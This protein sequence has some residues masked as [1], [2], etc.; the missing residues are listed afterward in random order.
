MTKHNILIINK[1]I[2]TIII[3]HNYEIDF[4]DN[5][6]KVIIKY[7]GNIVKEYERYKLEGKINKEIFPSYFCILFR[8]ENM[9][10]PILYYQYNSELEQISYS[11]NY[12]YNSKHLKD[13]P[14]PSVPEQDN[15][16]SY[17]SKYEENNIN[18]TPS[19]FIFL[20][21][22]SG[23]M[24]GRPI[25]L[26]KNALLLFIQ[27]LPKGSFFQLIGFGSSYN[28]YNEKPVEYNKENVEKISYTINNLKA[29]LGGTNINSPLQAVYNDDI[30]NNI[31]L[32]KNI[33]LLTDC[34][35]ND[36]EECI[37]IINNNSNRFRVHSLGL[38]D[39]FD[40]DLIEKS[41]QIGKGSY[42][43]V[44]NY[45]KINSAVIDT[46]NKSLRPYLIDIQFNFLNNINNNEKSII[47]CKPINN[48]T[49]QNEIINYS[50]ILDENNKID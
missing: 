39:S 5:Y 19:L 22:Q 37:N 21:D 32:S 45:E 18:D 44:E 43:F 30:Y 42:T 8:T 28:K 4:N 46:L 40:K 50:F 15:T 12:I 47:K 10:K 25:E 3:N 20:I 23:S 26:V 27:S 34:Q 36:S 7:S 2:L 24:S 16:L 38:G 48:Y 14:I 1:Y 49:Y 29:N 33:F 35:V 6:K 9:N 41:G 31:N 13:I 11:L 17:Y